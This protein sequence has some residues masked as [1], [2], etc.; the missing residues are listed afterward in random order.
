MVAIAA[1][2]LLES[3]SS[4]GPEVKR[5]VVGS[6]IV[7]NQSHR[8]TLVAHLDTSHVRRRRV[9]VQ[10]DAASKLAKVA[11]RF[12]AASLIILGDLIHHRLGI[13]PQVSERVAAWR[14]TVGGLRIEVVRGNHDRGIVLPE[15]WD[16]HEVADGNS[17]GPFRFCHDPVPRDDAAYTF[18][19]H[20]HPSVVLRRGADRVRLPCFLVGQRRV[21]LPAFGT[22]TGT[23]DVEPRPGVE[24]YLVAGDSV[25]AAP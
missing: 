5:L 17:R 21:I 12:E 20:L 23:Y 14:R 2:R 10:A 1:F 13:T 7:V 19:G 18:G 15:T 16:M 24:A 22:V 25:L 8:A 4:A 9:V 11:R 3:K 6:N